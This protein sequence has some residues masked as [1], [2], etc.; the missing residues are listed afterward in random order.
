MLYCDV[1]VSYYE[2]SKDAL[3]VV[4]LFHRLHF[5]LSNCLVTLQQWFFFILLCVVAFIWHI[6]PLC[7]VE[8]CGR[9]F[10]FFPRF[11]K[12]FEDV[13]IVLF[14]RH[15]L[16][17]ST[18]FLHHLHFLSHIYCAILQQWHITFFLSL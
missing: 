17:Y 10:F 3:A 12:C 7:L 2:C 13:S 4:F 14:L 5:P 15:Q 11:S 8:I 18:I 1:F 6:M 16:Y 9:F